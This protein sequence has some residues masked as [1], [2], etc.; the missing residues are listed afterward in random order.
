MPTQK[1]SIFKKKNNQLILGFI[2]LILILL[3]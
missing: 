1:I 3:I 2:F